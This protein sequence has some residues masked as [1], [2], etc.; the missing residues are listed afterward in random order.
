LRF[1]D[2][3]KFLLSFEFENCILNFSSFYKLKIKN[4]HFN[5]CKL[6]E[7]EF[8]GTDL[9]NSVFKNCDFRK[10]AFENT[11]LEK[12]DLRTSFNFSIN[13]ETNKISKAKFSKQNIIG[14]L[15]NYKII[16]E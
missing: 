9:T 2:C 13:P 8:V 6:E 4:T 14:L 3:N 1:D 7:V 15:D 11:L 16:V 5:N 10:A 12:A